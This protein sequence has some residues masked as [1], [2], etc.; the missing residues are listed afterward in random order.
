RRM[1]ETLEAMARALFRSWFVDF[2][3]VRA[4]AEGRPTGLPDDLATLFPD[5]FDSD[6]VP[7]GW[8]VGTVTAF[9]ELNPENWSTSNYPP[10]IQYVDLSN[11][12]W[13]TV[14]AVEIHSRS[15]APSRAQRR[16]RPG[17]T[18]FGTVRPGNGSY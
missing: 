16:L 4:K 18:I 6:E 1:A 7:T 10:S 9:A 11:T 15:S 3:P 17:D 8:S 12:K 14:E 2:D 13:G 5:S